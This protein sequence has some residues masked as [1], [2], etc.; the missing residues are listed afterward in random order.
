MNQLNSYLNKR[1]SASLTT[2]DFRFEFDPKEANRSTWVII[3]SQHAAAS[4]LFR[5]YE[6][7]RFDELFTA[8]CDHQSIKQMAT[9]CPGRDLLQLSTSL[10]AWH[11][12][13]LQQAFNVLLCR[14]LVCSDPLERIR[15]FMLSAAQQRYNFTFFINASKICTVGSSIINI[16]VATPSQISDG[17]LGGA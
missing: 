9:F 15:C 17:L 2:F 11:F 14:A 12:I 5:V 13:D 3:Y 1:K 7:H 4:H 16:T 8:C 10:R 6:V